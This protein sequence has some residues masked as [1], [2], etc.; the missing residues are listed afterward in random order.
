M[1]A[2]PGPLPTRVRQV[3]FISMELAIGRLNAFGDGT[4]QVVGDAARVSV[5]TGG[6]A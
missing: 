4:V 6:R 1:E 3:V 2:N 5:C